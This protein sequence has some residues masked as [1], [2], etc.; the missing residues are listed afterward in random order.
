MKNLTQ[1]IQDQKVIILKTMFSLPAETILEIQKS[2]E[3]FFINI[4]HNEIERK[5]GMLKGNINEGQ[6]GKALVIGYNTAIN[7]DI[8]YWQNVLEGLEKNV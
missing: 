7:E 2:T 3:Q 6:T 8:S 5:K 1:L 4:I